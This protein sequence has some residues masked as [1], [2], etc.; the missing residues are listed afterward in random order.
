MRGDNVLARIS[1]RID[2]ISDR[3]DGAE[4]LKEVR[5]ALALANVVY[6]ADRLPGQKA[7]PTIHVT[8]PEAWVEHYWQQNFFAVD[9]VLHQG[10]RT[11]LPLDWSTLDRAHPRARLMFD[12]AQEFGVGHRGLT[13]PIRGPRGERALFS[14]TSNAS[15][16]EWSDFSR[17]MLGE[18]QILAFHVH[19]MIMRVNGVSAEAPKLSKREIECLVW[20]G[21]GKTMADVADILS[22]SERT[23]RFHCDTA[24]H[25]LGSLHIAQAVGRAVYMGIIPP[26]LL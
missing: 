23:V 25:K 12:R 3:G 14:V 9:P 24:R 6:L 11:L 21:N 19:D 18:L 2:R 4:I 17:S 26:P 5:D 15:E 10:F 13:F 16:R 8:Y 22:L 20:I 7:E 1:E